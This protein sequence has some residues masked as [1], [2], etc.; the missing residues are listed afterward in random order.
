MKEQKN[1]VLVR[2]GARCIT[3]E[4]MEQVGGFGTQ[5]IVI[6]HQ[7]TN[8]GQDSTVDEITQ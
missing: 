7:G 6:T 2:K 5:F 8:M 3:R 4:E 1:R